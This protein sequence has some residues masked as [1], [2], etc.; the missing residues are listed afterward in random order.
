MEIL[1]YNLKTGVLSVKY[2]T[3][4]V[5]EYSPINEDTFYQIMGAKSSNS[6]VKNI[7]RKLSIV[8][9]NKGVM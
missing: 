5:W 6:K 7:L 9:E 2:N 8:G 1:S 3:K 4:T